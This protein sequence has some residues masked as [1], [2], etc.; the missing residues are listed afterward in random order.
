MPGDE[1]ALSKL[2][3]LIEGKIG[4]GDSEEWVNQD[5]LSLSGKIQEETKVSLSHM[6]LKRIW[7]KVK[8]DSLPNTYTLNTL[9]QFAGFENWRDF[10]IK[11]DNDSTIEG[12]NTGSHNISGSKEI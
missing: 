9:A 11:S 3:K 4:W 10:K 5:F 1:K 12:T 8:Y 2:K 6:T 7:G